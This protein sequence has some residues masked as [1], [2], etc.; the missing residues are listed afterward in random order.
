MLVAVGCGCLWV[1]GFAMFSCCVCLL[2]VVWFVGW[3]FANA[4]INSVVVDD[5]GGVSFVDL[6][7]W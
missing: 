2:I 6:I 7:L 3:G 5:C 1:A 4:P